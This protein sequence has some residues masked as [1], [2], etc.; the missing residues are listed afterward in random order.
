[1]ASN[2]TVKHSVSLAASRDGSLRSIRL[3]PPLQDIGRYRQVVAAASTIASPDGL[4]E[5]PSEKDFQNSLY[6]GST[7][8][9][10]IYQS[11]AV[12]LEA[13]RKVAELLDSLSLLDD[14][15]KTIEP[16]RATR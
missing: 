11:E 15:D 2:E 4:S 13:G 7:E 9:R 3:Q 10:F 5:E 16:A 14:F 12:Q 8:L 1:M 6:A